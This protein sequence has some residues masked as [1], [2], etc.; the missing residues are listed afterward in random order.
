MN[1]FERSEKLGQK[2]KW[3]DFAVLKLSVLFATLFL[4]G[5]FEGFKNAVLSINSIWYLVISLV[6]SVYLIIKMFS[7]D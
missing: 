6:L 7:D 3:Y 2:M 1:K 4:V 5:F